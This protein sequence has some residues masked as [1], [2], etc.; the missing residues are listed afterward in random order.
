MVVCYFFNLFIICFVTFVRV[1]RASAGKRNNNIRSRQDKNVMCDNKKD[2]NPNRA[3]SMYYIIHWILS[4]WCSYHDKILYT[5]LWDQF[6]D[7]LLYRVHFDVY[8][9]YTDLKYQQSA[10]QNKMDNITYVLAYVKMLAQDPYPCLF[11]WDAGEH[12]ELVSGVL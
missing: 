3:M 6:D 12:S 11:C 7:P 5:F 9:L 8:L 4:S 2:E 1:Q 10:P